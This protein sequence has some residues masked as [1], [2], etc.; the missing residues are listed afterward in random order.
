VF[1]EPE[2]VI[3][4][5][6]KVHDPGQFDCGTA[7]LTEWLQRFAWTNHQSGSARVYAA[8]RRDN[9]IVGYHSLTAGSVSREDAPARI[10]KGLANHP[11]GVILLGRLAVHSGFQGKGLGRALL[12]DA[13]TRAAQAADTVGVR[14]LLVHAID[15][16][17]RRFYMHF[18]FQ[19][20]PVDSMHLTLLMRDLRALRRA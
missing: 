19:P 2:F 17:A 4:G 3:E 1:P 9:V 12:L 18:D 6:T 15:E 13:L 10:A 14:A 20:S 7:S 11:I 5:L 16:S 8:H